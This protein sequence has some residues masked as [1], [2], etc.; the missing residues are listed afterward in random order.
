WRKVTG[1]GMRQA[2]LLAAAGIHAL[3]NNVE[4]LAE[5][6]ANARRL[7]DGLRDA[8][9]AL[10]EEPQTNMVFVDMQDRDPQA[11]AARLRDRGVIITPAPVLRLVTHLDVSAKDV[12]RVIEAFR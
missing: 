2:G 6:H 10:A 1:G 7:A 11:F 12:A 4:R 9:F 5:D 3:E 8:G